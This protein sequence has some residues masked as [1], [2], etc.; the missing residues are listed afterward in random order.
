MTP[1]LMDLHIIRIES[2][3]DNL[4]VEGIVP[5][6]AAYWTVDKEMDRYERKL[7]RGT[8]EAIPIGYSER[9]YMPMDSGL[10]PARLFVGHDAIQLQRNYGRKD[11]GREKYHPGLKERYEYMTVAQYGAMIDLRVG[12][13]VYFHPSVTE[14]EN[15]LEKDLYL[16]TVDQLICGVGWVPDPITSEKPLEMLQIRPQGGFVLIEPVMD[17]QLESDGIVIRQ[18]AEAVLLEGIVR[19]AR[20]GSGLEEGEHIYYLENADWV[21]KIEGVVYYAMREEEI[22]GSKLKTAI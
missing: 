9:Q 16:A 19:H 12:E 1:R 18:E 2:I 14:P 6:N 21:L 13:R 10:P 3:W 22:I 11:W 8:V 15:R 7:L 17:T 5:M 20:R 4:P